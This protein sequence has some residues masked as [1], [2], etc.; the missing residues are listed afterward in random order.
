MAEDASQFSQFVVLKFYTG[1]SP[2]SG[3]TYLLLVHPSGQK[4][5]CQSCII[6]LSQLS[7]AVLIN[8]FGQGGIWSTNCFIFLMHPF[9][10]FQ[11]PGYLY[12]VDMKYKFLVKP[13]FNIVIHN[14]RSCFI[15]NK[16][17]CVCSIIIFN[18]AQVNNSLP[19][20]NASTY[21]FE[22]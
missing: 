14:T 18:E 6:W 16:S 19:I 13:L 7:M 17:P 9:H 3:R 12:L 2:I 11:L 4:R 20:G 8:F 1:R 15:I 21:Y 10:N 22:V 5:G